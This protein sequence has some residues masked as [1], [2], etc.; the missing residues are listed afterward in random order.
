MQED[1]R[2]TERDF[3]ADL[4]EARPRIVGALFT[5]MSGALRE[6]DSVSLPRLP[7]LADFAK[8]GVAAEK[9]L[10][11][12]SGA[13]MEAYELNRAEAGAQAL[14][15]KFVVGKLVSWI[16]AIVPN[17]PNGQIIR[18]FTGT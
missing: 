15:S 4:E 18:R 5:A 1:E 11:F 7:R 2:K 6:L 14:E 10:G 16:Q 12:N 13:F 9:A 17:R 3:W 8:L